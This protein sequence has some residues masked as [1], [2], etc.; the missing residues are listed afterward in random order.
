MPHA[1]QDIGGGVLE[2][3][4]KDRADVSRKATEEVTLPGIWS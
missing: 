3:D 1:R 2:A 4:E